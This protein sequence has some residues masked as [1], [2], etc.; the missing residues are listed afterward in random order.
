MNDEFQFYQSSLIIHH[1]NIP[2]AKLTRLS[3]QPRY[4]KE[5]R[6]YHQ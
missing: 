4:I 6:R 5:Y 2:A 3:E 1:S